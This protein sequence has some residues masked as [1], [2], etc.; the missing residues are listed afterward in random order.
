MIALLR[1][2]FH[3][4]DII[5]YMINIIIREWSPTPKSL[6]NK[7]KT[8]KFHFRIYDQNKQKIIKTI[9]AETKEEIK[10]LQRKYEDDL[11]T[12]IFNLKNPK[13]ID[14]ALIYLA[15]EKGK[16]D[17]GIIKKTYY[18]DINRNWNKLKLLSKDGQT[19]LEKYPIKDID[20]QYLKL[21]SDKMLV[22]FTLRDN[23][24]AWAT[25]GNI[26][27][28]AFYNKM[29][30][31]FGLTKQVNRSEFRSAKKRH[32]PK[33]PEI[34]KGLNPEEKLLPTL[35][36]VLHY[37]KKRDLFWYNFYFTLALF[38]GRISEVIPLTSLDYNTELHY[39][40]IN[41][42]TNIKE[43]VTA[44]V[45]K[46]DE[47]EGKVYCGP[48]YT[49]EIYLPW[50]NELK[51]FKHNPKQLLYPSREGTT[52]AYK[53]ILKNIKNDFKSIGFKGN[54]STHTF[55]SFGAVI[56]GYLGVDAQKHLRH[57]SEAMT[58]LYRRGKEWQMNTV[59]NENSDKVAK[60][61]LQ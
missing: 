34:F 47:S 12:G 58:K 26:L 54:V 20:I 41:K 39:F 1:I 42:T 45:F 40:D 44:E 49:N 31:Q 17:A 38:N 36:K 43:N 19:T 59:A 46:T 60:L 56:R 50:L 5:Q 55:R 7:N 48:I 52:K 61:L 32:K 18:D 10:K 28:T 35:R 16:L 15:K 27:D 25:L 33:T 51:K 23:K 21:L 37:T 30:V 4:V 22:E 13:V 6:L 9:F 24:N 2:F 29:G 14:A 3:I 57:T 53:V 11:K 8:N